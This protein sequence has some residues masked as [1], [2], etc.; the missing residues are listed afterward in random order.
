MTEG[1]GR[2]LSSWQRSLGSSLSRG[3]TNNLSG[4]NGKAIGGGGGGC[5][6]WGG[7]GEKESKK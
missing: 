2:P 3:R 4:R 5:G 6:G 1:R 7:R